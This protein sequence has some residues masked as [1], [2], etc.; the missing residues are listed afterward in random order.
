MNIRLGSFSSNT[1]FLEWDA[2]PGA[3]HYVVY[4]DGE[5][6]NDVNQHWISDF[7]FLIPNWTY[8]YYVEARTLD[9]ILIETSQPFELTFQRPP[10]KSNIRIL[11]V[12]ADF[13]DYTGTKISIETIQAIMNNVASLY[14]GLGLGITYDI[15]MNHHLGLT[16]DYCGWLGTNNLG[17]S[18]NFPKIRSELNINTTGY[19]NVIYFV[20]G[21]GTVGLS[22]GMYMLV[23]AQ[24]IN[25]SVIAHELGHGLGAWHAGSLT[26]TSPINM[27]NIASIL[28]YSD[29]YD[30]MGAVWEKPSLHHQ[31]CMGLTPITNFNM[32][33][34][35][36]EYS[37]LP[38]K[39]LR[40]MAKSKFK[41]CFWFLERYTDNSVILRLHLDRYAQGNVDADTAFIKRIYVGQ[42]YTLPDQPIV[43]TAKTSSIQI[44]SVIN[45]SS[46][47]SSSDAIPPRKKPG[48]NRK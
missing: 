8:T 43:I 3:S 41:A 11:C 46:S 10:N 48:R 9:N 15:L 2:I 38:G 44:S 21:L 39:C 12:Q 20:D 4:R 26:I 23:S 17:Y 37:L 33:T 7:Y 28:R 16:L 1:T 35:N 5:L 31:L 22:G 45:S 27:D 36:G 34:S 47:S 30:L 24:H 18:P 19:D 32:I 6:L 13:S 25:N 40:I 14:N 42:S 29:P